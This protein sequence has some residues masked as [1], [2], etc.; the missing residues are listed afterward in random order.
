MEL[1]RQNVRKILFIVAFGILLYWGLKNLPAFGA[2]IAFVLHFLA[3]FIAGACLAFILCVPLRFIENRLFAPLNRRCKRIWPKLRR[4]VSIVLVYALLFGVTLFVILMVIP[5]LVR[6]VKLLA[7]SVPTAVTHLQSW[8][9]RLV[10]DYPQLS[11]WTASLHLDWTNISTTIADFLQNGVTKVLTSTLSVATT[12]IDA[13]VNLIITLI[14]S[15][16][17]ILQ[18]EKLGG[19][20]K[21]LLYAFLPEQKSDRTIEILA[22]SHKTFSNFIT[23]QFTEAVILGCLCFVGMQI[24][25]FPYSAMISVLIGFMALIPM[26]GAFISTIIGALL[27]LMISPIQ[28]LWFVIF[29]LILQQI[30]GNLIYPRVVGS[31]VGLPGMWVLVAVV[32]GSSLYGI[33]GMLFSVPLCSVIY[34]LLRE[35]VRRRVKER[36][37]ERIKMQ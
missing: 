2:G 13:A 23:G 29:I 25:R 7:D 36:G 28:A 33:V 1:N 15:I 27:I 21:R 16:Y 17:V 34:C 22:L 5:E 3:P 32:V 31:S 4:P 20:A 24:F 14:F 30:E 10:N 9:N 12:I 19:Q 6:T 37:V 11:E 26:V 35:T 8:L 18:K